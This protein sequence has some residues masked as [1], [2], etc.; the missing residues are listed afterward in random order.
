MI[1]A[2]HGGKEALKLRTMRGIGGEVVKL[3]GVVLQIIEFNDRRL[4][5][6]GVWVHLAED[7][8]GFG[9]LSFDAN[10]L[11]VDAIQP[12]FHVAEI[13]VDD[14]WFVEPTAEVMM[15]GIEHAAFFHAARLIE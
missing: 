4:F 2:L 7:A 10:S 8:V 9:E 15:R 13:G 1:H 3:V 12:G 11:A 6:E 5:A 14:F